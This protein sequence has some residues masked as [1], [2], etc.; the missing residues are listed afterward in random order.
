M[1]MIYQN[2]LKEDTMERFRHRIRR[3]T[4]GDLAKYC[5]TAKD[6]STGN[7]VGVS[8]WAM[9]GEPPK[10]RA[11]IDKSF[12]QDL[13]KREM[14]P[15][16]E[17]INQELNDAFFKAAYYSEMETVAGQ[18][19]ICLR[20]LAVNPKYHRC[21]VGSLLLRQALDKADELGL[22]VYLDCG[23]MGKPLYERFGFKNVG[24]F[25]LNCLD[26]GGRSDGRHWLMLR[27]SNTTESQ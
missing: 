26:Y 22:P 21:G 12:E 23:V 14:E 25:P 19:Y 13:E 2:G 3:H 11:A 7:I 27:P 6:R 20:I 24:D 9:T 16:V 4:G 17:G 15:P 8:W 10:G 1:P 18:P 5:S